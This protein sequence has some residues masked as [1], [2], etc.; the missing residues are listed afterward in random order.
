MRPPVKVIACVGLLLVAYAASVGIGVYRL[1]SSDA[2]PMAKVSLAGYLAALKSPDAAESFHLKWFAPWQFSSGLN[3]G[4]T[5][6]LMCTPTA[7]CYIVKAHKF[8]G[9]WAVSEVIPV[10]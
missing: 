8:R 9:K 4:R 1:T 2:F 6:F 7:H 3:S 5:Q 10:R